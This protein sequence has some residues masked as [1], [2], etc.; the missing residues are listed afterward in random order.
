MSRI[1]WL[2]HNDG[3][4]SCKASY[5]VENKVRVYYHENPIINTMKVKYPIIETIVLGTITIMAMKILK[6]YDIE[7]FMQTL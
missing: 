2:N 6:N 1:T 5:H 7:V 3:N 4:Y